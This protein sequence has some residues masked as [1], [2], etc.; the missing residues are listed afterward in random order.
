MSH[1]DDYSRETRLTWSRMRGLEDLRP[2][3]D[4]V[5]PAGAAVDGAAMPGEYGGL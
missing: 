2:V 4:Q 3:L 5:E 1:D